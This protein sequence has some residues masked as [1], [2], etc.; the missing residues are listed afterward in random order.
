MPK[1]MYMCSYSTEGL[2]GLQKDKA[3][4]RRAA[5]AKAAEA[6]GG[7]LD[8]VYFGLGEYDAYVICD[9]PD[10]ATATAIAVTVSATGLVHTKTV[11]LFTVEETDR[12]LSKTVAF[13][14]PGR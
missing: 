4:G 14:P 10:M 12:A 2:K 6:V 8:A 9:L 5:M 1:F 13:T 3:S 7:K 11:P